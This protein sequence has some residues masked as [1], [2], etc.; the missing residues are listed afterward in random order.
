MTLLNTKQSK[1]GWEE[2]QGTGKPYELVI[3][4]TAVVLCDGDGKKKCFFRTQDELQV[5]VQYVA[6]QSIFNPVFRVQIFRSDGLF[7]HGM[8]TERHE[9]NLGRIDGEGTII[10]RYPAL[11]LLNG[12]YSIR[13]S[14][15]L[16]QYVEIPLH[17][18]VVSQGIHMESKMKDG[19]GIFAMPTEWI[20]SRFDDD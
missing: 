20:P 5:R 8:N 11:K 16:S 2:R 15:L 18:F 19:G 17:E 1:D 10:L 9:M 7:C 4:I 6:H 13:V 3:E 12:D 14:V